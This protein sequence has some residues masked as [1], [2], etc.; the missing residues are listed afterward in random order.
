M[1]TSNQHKLIRQREEDVIYDSD[2]YAEWVRETHR[3][4]HFLTEQHIFDRLNVVW[5]S[6]DRRFGAWAMTLVE[7][8]DGSAFNIDGP[9]P[10]PDNILL[11][12]TI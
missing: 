9:N 2:I 8:K 3:H 7:F 11:R 4:P 1:G 10:G 12:S 6:M 5:V